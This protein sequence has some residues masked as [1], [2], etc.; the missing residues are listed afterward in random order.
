[1][2]AYPRFHGTSYCW[3]TCVTKALPQGCWRSV[4]CW[5][6]GF[7]WLPS[8]AAYG[9]CLA[10]ECVGVHCRVYGIL[11]PQVMLAV[12]VCRI[13][14][15]LESETLSIPKSVLVDKGPCLSLVDG[16]EH[17]CVMS[18]SKTVLEGYACSGSFYPSSKSAGCCPGRSYNFLWL[19]LLSMHLCPWHLTVRQEAHP[20]V[21]QHSLY[22]LR[23]GA[24]FFYF[25]RWSNKRVAMSW[26]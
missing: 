17:V 2:L 5:V 8:M 21:G 4:V 14:W 26:W 1:M 25:A 22:C 13:A 10:Q 18:L 12:F 20:L 7:S 15:D 9:R 11:L 19:R 23:W 3:T 24:Q 16:M 6:W